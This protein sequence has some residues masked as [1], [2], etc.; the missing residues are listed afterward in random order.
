MHSADQKASRGPQTARRRSPGRYLLLSWAGVI[1]AFAMVWLPELRAHW[2]SP[3]LVPDAIVEKAREV[4][5]RPVLERISRQPLGVSVG[6]DRLSESPG[7]SVVDAAEHLLSG[8]SRFPSQPGVRLSVPFEESNLVA[9]PP[10]HWLFVASLGTAD[11]LL[12]AYRQT[13]AERYLRAAAR[14]IEAFARVDRRRLLPSG[15]LWNDHALAA[16]IPMLASYWSLVRDRADLD[17]DHARQMLSLVERAVTRLARPQNYTF[18]TNHGL[19]QSLAL[20]QA[21][22][23]FPFLDEDGQLRSLACGRIAEQSEYYLSPEGP[24]LEHSAGYH[25]LGL[26]LYSIFEE[27]VDL[28]SCA[29]PADFASKLARARAFGAQLRRPD[30]SMPTYGNTDRAKRIWTR[31]V[32][33]TTPATSLGLYPASGFAVKWHGLKDWPAVER[34]AQSVLTWS[35][36]PS[37][38]HKLA[39]DMSLVIWA[40]GEE[41]L[42]N[43]GYWPYGV[44][45]EHSA[46]GWRGG[47]A[48]HWADEPAVGARR[49]TLRTLGDSERIWAIEV[50]RTTI[51]SAATVRR[52]I[53]AID[54]RLWVIVDSTDEAA[55]RP[56][57][58]LWTLTPDIRVKRIGNSDFQLRSAATSRD[59]RLAI[60]Q[61]QQGD[62]KLAH[63][64]VD[65]F[66]GWTV[67]E[68]V[69]TPSPSIE[70]VSEGPRALTVTVFA[71]DQ[72]GGLVAAQAPVL[73]AHAS[74]ESWGI[75]LAPAFGARSV[76]WEGDGVAVQF[77]D[78]NS[79]HV[80]LVAPPAGTE[81]RRAAIVAAYEAAASRHARFPYLL[82]YRYRVTWILVALLLAQEAF[83]LGIRRVAP[84]IGPPLRVLA[85]VAWVM[86][87][88][89]A[90]FWYLQ[91]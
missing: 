32:G 29:M 39:D 70:A 60:M 61:R 72:D 8:E 56:L 79:S 91:L 53:A 59:A 84:P 50:E 11:V 2:A 10:S 90:A 63:G 82:P 81:E 49:A 18:R 43:T 28:H 80:A 16:M 58:T 15:L 75:R 7:Q 6:S 83:F 3:F 51:G 44:A 71:L 30:G 55:D 35:N 64:S 73:D 88:G 65:P 13:G 46:R 38:A 66:A 14:E 25:V 87:G 37:R 86:L 62:T 36:F 74:A 57:S 24:I 20:L 26:E 33:S 69:P 76:R 19:M 54:G 47:N 89:V 21:S 68:S 78:G 31:L 42:L 27:L 23:A 45:G 22:A 85:T 67:Y 40:G 1:V 12:R 52:Q 41:W 48:P 4:P 5:D 9:G 17:V 34:L 77:V